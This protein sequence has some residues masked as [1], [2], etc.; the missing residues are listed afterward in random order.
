VIEFAARLK[1][2]GVGTVQGDRYGGEW[3]RERFAAHGIRYEPYEK[4]KS[5]VLPALNAHPF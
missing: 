3:P 5:D 4:P 2:Y 1:S